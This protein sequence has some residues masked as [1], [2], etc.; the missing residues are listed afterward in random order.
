MLSRVQGLAWLARSQARLGQVGLGQ[1]RQG[2][3]A[4]ELWAGYDQARAWLECKKLPPDVDSFGVFCN[5]RIDLSE[6]GQPE[7]LVMDDTHC[8]QVEVYGYDYDYTLASYK[9]GVEYLIHDIAR[10]HLVKRSEL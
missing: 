7:T 4:A 6:V 3:T 1:A 9:K 8:W 2:H 10:E 5:D